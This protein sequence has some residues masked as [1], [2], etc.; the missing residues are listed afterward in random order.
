MQEVQAFLGKVN[1]YGKFL[2]NMAALCAPLNMLKRKGEVFH[3]DGEQEKAFQTLKA[4]LVRFTELVHFRVDLPLILATDASAYGVGAVLLHRFADGS[5]KPIAHASKTLN[6][7]QRA[8][9]QVEKEALSIVFGVHKFHQYLYGRQFELVTDHKPLVAI[10]HPSKKLPVMTAH[11]LQRWAIALMGYTF[12]IRYKATAQ[13]GNAD[14][15]SR[16]PCGP[17]YEFDQEVDACN[18]ISDLESQMQEFP[19]RV[20]KMA[21]M[22]V[23]DAT[24][25]QVKWFMQHGWPEKLKL[26]QDSLRPY[27]IR[28]HALAVYKDVI[29]WHSEYPRVIVPDCIRDYVLRRLHEGHWGMVRMKQLAR[30]YCWWP[31]MDEAIQKMVG[32]CSICQSNA[33]E[34]AKSFVSWPKPT[35]PWQRLHV[36]FCG[37]FFDKMWF[38]CV[39]AFSKFPY[40]L[41][42][43]ST[44]TE[45]TVEAL[46]S[47]FA[48]EGLPEVIVSDNGRQFVAEEFASFCRQRGI[49]HIT[50]AP[51]HP[52][53]NG[54]AERFVRTFKSAVNKMVAGGRSIAMAVKAVLLSFRTTPNG[55][56]GKTPAERLHGRQPR[57]VLDLL[58]PAV[59]RTDEQQEPEQ[60]RRQM[61]ETEEE[62]H[63]GSEVYVRNFSSGPKWIPGV[64]DTRLGNVNYRVS[65]E[66]GLVKRHRNQMRKRLPKQEGSLMELESVALRRSQRLRPPGSPM[67]SESVPLRRSH[68]IRRPVVRFSPSTD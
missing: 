38:I 43:N 44:T 49:I 41:Q 8:Y 21:R 2:R 6:D 45:A 26:G 4:E 28:R 35:K 64:I 60:G 23:E 10:F 36:D 37:P 62:W 30:R 58:C 5:E 53:S 40:I 47:L 22:S 48:M 34:P 31:K 14:G 67:E 55:S 12:D 18:E 52:A 59:T 57:I 19:V 1:Y 63:T 3:W 54:E 33:A 61:E 24:L 29:V 50:S 9:S 51:Y 68:R 39:D 15:L 27:F 46:E 42:M 17:D 7:A 56:D 13:H 66:K 11:R 25:K 32:E 65:T 20:D 16:L